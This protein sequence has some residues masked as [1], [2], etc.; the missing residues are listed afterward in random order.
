MDILKEFDLKQRNY[1]KEN[2]LTNILNKIKRPL[3]AKEVINIAKEHNINLQLLKTL[4]EILYKPK[5]IWYLH[6]IGAQKHLG[7]FVLLKLNEHKY[8]HKEI[9]IIQIFTSQNLTDDAQKELAEFHREYKI[10]ILPVTNYTVQPVSFYDSVPDATCG[11]WCAYYLIHKKLP[12][13]FIP[14]DSLD[15]KKP[16]KETIKRDEHIP[17]KVKLNNDSKLMDS[18]QNRTK[19]IEDSLKSMSKFKKG[20]SKYTKFT[21]NEDGKLIKI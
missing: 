11:R 17:T 10:P 1:F 16:E 19:H 21:I 18:I 3:F 15:L 20:L 5:K 4:D 14:L 12:N 2:D 9:K 6:I 7:H 8:K 13:D